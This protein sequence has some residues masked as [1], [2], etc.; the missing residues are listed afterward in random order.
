MEE[1]KHRSS[2]TPAIHEIAEEPHP[3]YIKD[4]KGDDSAAGSLDLNVDPCKISNSMEILREFNKIFDD[5]L[6]KVDQTQSSENIKVT[7]E[8][9]FFI[10]FGN[11]LL[12]NS[13]L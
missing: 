1:D 12:L 8:T 5:R 6:A 13:Y 3:R 9:F 7:F 11:Y 2:P 4:G 10:L